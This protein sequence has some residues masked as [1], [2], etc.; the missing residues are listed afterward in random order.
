MPGTIPGSDNVT[1]NKTDKEA[2]THGA[3]I[4][5]KTARKKKQIQWTVYRK[6]VSAV[7]NNKSGN[8]GVDLREERNEGGGQGGGVYIVEALNVALREMP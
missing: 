4:L 2:H 8:E 1:V 6:A 5:V 3:H 7:M